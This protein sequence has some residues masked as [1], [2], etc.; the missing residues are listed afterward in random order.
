MSPSLAADES[1]MR[2]AIALAERGRGRVEPNPMVGAV[3]VREGRVVAEGFHERYGGPHA[4]AN[5][6][7]R[8]GPL[9]KGATL[10]VTLEPCTG[11][12]K[13]TPP[14]CEAVIE[15]GFARVVIG[16]RDPTREP[17]VP[18]LREA[19]IE[20]TT[21]VLEEDCRALIAPFLTL[22]LLGRPFV[23][24]KWAMTADGRMSAAGGDSRWISSDVSR[25]LV[26]RWRGEVNA[27]LV[28]SGTVRRDD[29]LLTCR[30]PGARQPV[31]VVLD[32]R[33][34]LPPESRLA[35]TVSQAPLLVACHEDAPPE[36][37]RLLER[38]GCRILALPGPEGRPDIGLL[39]DALGR[40][41]MTYLMVEGGPTVL[42]AFFDR[43][44]IDE[45]RV[46]IAPRLM[47]G[48]AA[49]YAVP[50]V[51]RGVATAQEAVELMRVTWEAVGPDILLTGR[52]RPAPT[53]PPD[54]LS[55]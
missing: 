49:P 21:G 27:V 24:A 2:M 4:E 51:G 16:A 33:A 9:C 14:C 54:N 36:N 7:A 17:A 50:L 34:A 28:G 1:Y 6:I 8:A 12:R 35:G 29:P 30:V 3:V 26:Q 47:G 19:G 25:Q 18:R 11:T 15:A 20:V 23:I 32:S 43:G 52:T 31:R 5:A 44:L 41:E 46:F 53:S 42:G 39:L 10:Y 37:R 55:E 48:P 22:R 45:V 38:R 40:E 13:K